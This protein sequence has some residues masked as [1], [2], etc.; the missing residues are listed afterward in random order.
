MAAGS[1]GRIVRGTRIA[2]VAALAVVGHLCFAAGALANS[3][4]ANGGTLG[5]I[6]DGTASTPGS[7]GPPRDVTFTVTGLPTG[8][9]P[10]NVALTFSGT[11]TWIGDLDV[12]LIAPNGDSATIFS[13]TGAATASGN[14]SGANLGGP[15]TFT[16]KAKATPTWW[17]HASSAGLAD[18][19]PAGVFRATTPGGAA[20]GGS[21]VNMTALFD[22]VTNPNGTW[23]LRVRDGFAGDL[24]SITAASLDL[25]T[26]VSATP[27]SLGTIPDGLSPPSYGTPLNVTFPV[28]GL[29]DAPPGDVSIAMVINHS[30]VGD[31]DAVLIAP[32]GTTKTTVF[33]RTGAATSVPGDDSDLAG[34]YT[35]T[36]N[37]QPTATSWWD[38]AAA[39]GPTTAVPSG[40]YRASTPGGE[41][42]GGGAASLMTSAFSTL[43][44]PNGTWT[45]RLRDHAAQDLGSITVGELAIVP[46]TDTSAPA[47]PVLSG[48]DPVSPANA[49][50]PKVQGTAEQGSMVRVYKDPVCGGLPAVTGTAAQFTGAGIPVPVADDGPNMFSATAYDTSGN[51][52]GCTASP[53]SYTEDS[54]PPAAPTLSAL[55][56]PANDN[57]PVIHGSGAEPGSTV[58]IYGDAGCT[59]PAASSESA[60]QFNGA[61]TPVEVPD[62]ATI[63]FAVKAV[64]AA[65]NASACSAPIT[66]VEDSTSGAP[67]I[68]GTD[69]PPPAN[70]NAPK[71]RGTGA[72]ADATVQVYAGTACVGLS[73]FDGTA[74]QFGGAG[75]P[76]AVLDNTSQAFVAE[77]FDAAGN[78]SSCSAPFTYTEDSTAPAAPSLAGTDPVSGSDQNSPRIKGSAEA[79]SAVTL[80][81]TSDCSGTP[82]A[83]GSGA[84]LAGSGIAVSV[85]DNS[86]ADF[87]ALA[88]DAAGNASPC[89][90]PISYS[91]VTVL[92]Q[93][94]LIP[95]DTRID[96]APKRKVKTKGKAA[97]FS[98]AF[99]ANE[100]STFRCSLDKAAFAPCASPATGK[101]KKGSH[102]F[103]V[104]ATDTSGNPDPTPAT[105]SWKVK[106]LKKHRHH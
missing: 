38:A 29:P 9:S 20:S 10:F 45:L 35:F 58:R 37:L 95:P 60:G 41:V 67:A 28:S 65:G 19:V 73:D 47:A 42:A 51:V 31:L 97:S 2:S 61:G 56:S 6:P 88:T 100:P 66:Y 32:D 49:N 70:N 62:D 22:N 74:S 72:D 12:V 71:L 33:S 76:I 83:S 57:F 99:S 78:E 23:T 5:E 34:A 105:A 43:T 98:I 79:G 44:H 106:R 11:H 1:R 27:G 63:A 7:Y 82:A 96:S 55:M 36:D 15:Y 90:A 26:R 54:T 103:S 69:P 84:D 92:A 52:S 86:T 24:G 77:A 25:S 40:S 4:P 75:I 3:F 13:R 17:T 21:N 53:I 14:G 93:P 68:T 101:A 102:T 16:D 8:H 87:R 85:A 89:S 50:T 18:V 64:D 80:F 81:T 48:T 39:V 91:E 94:D 59:E 30:F 104:I 46:G